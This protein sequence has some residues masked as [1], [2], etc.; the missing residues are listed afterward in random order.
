MLYSKFQI[1][2]RYCTLTVEYWDKIYSNCILLGVNLKQIYQRQKK[3][4]TKTGNRT[5]YSR[6]HAA[7]AFPDKTYMSRLIILEYWYPILLGIFHA[8][9]K[10]CELKMYYLGEYYLKR[11]IIVGMQQYIAGLDKIYCSFAT[12]HW[13]YDAINCDMLNNNDSQPQHI[14]G[15]SP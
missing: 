13:S 9:R 1:P 12:H 4:R 2:S 5:C 10:Y 11:N 14:S 3:N 8:E 15:H 7:F 6:V